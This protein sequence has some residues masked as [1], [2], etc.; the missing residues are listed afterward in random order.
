MKILFVNPCLRRGMKHRLLPVGLGYIVTAAKNAGFD[1]DLLDIEL[2]HYEDEDIER[3]IRTHGYDVIAFGCMVSQ[4]RWAKRF[5]RMV[6]EYQPHCTIIVGNSVGSSCPE[7][8]MDNAPVD[9]IVRGEG[10][11]TIVELLDAIKRGIALSPVPR[12]HKPQRM[13]LLDLKTQKAPDDGAVEGILFRTTD[14]TIIDNGPRKAIPKVDEIPWPDWDIFEIE[15]YLELGHHSVQQTTLYPREKA[16]PFPV[17]TARGCIFKCTFCHYVFWHD[18]YRHRSPES[19]IGEMRRN[20]EKW[21]GNY[22]NLQDE[23]S[24]YKVGPTEKFLDALLEANLDIHFTCSTR[25]DLFGRRDTPFEDRLRVARKLFRAGCVYSSFGLESADPTILEAMN[26][27][28]TP[29]HVAEHV[30]VLQEAEVPVAP[31][32]IIGYPQETVET[33]R[34]TY[35]FC[36]NL[37]LYPSSGYLLPMPATGMW[38]YAVKNGFIPDADAYLSNITER[39]DLVL[40]MTRLPDEVILEEVEAGCQRANMALGLNLTAGELIRTGGYKR[41]VASRP[42]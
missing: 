39:Q 12:D 10:D 24:F 1:F 19:V 26:K 5:I 38:D 9:I 27:R 20:K 7:L 6:K 37:G 21:G 34:A 4:Y 40:N 29:E 41:H 42:T 3:F 23:L 18:P 17:N 14:G 22:F 31:S 16:V 36:I 11:V 25:S 35:D 32:I 13:P 15:R 30:R 33:I 8:L 28:V 2:H